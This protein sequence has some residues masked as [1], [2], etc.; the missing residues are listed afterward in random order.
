[1]RGL[2]AWASRPAFKKTAWSGALLLVVVH[3]R[4]SA[5]KLRGMM[6]CALQVVVDCCRECLC[7]KCFA[8]RH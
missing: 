5:N 2:F 4:R 3:A 8:A 7:E 1:M 6:N